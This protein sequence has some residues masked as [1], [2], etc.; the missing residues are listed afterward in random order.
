M[1]SSDL[2]DKQTSTKLFTN[3]L[4]K[5]KIMLKKL[6]FLFPA[7]NPHLIYETL[8]S[9]SYYIALFEA[10]ANNQHSKALRL[11]DQLVSISN[12]GSDRL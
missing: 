5:L 9:C 11:A 1:C 7:K 10:I 8:Q 6:K 12:K 3:E 4:Q 2:D